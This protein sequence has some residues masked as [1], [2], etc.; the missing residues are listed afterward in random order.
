M[1]GP[2]SDRRGLAV[3]PTGRSS[4]AAKQAALERLSSADSAD[5]ERREAYA[6]PQGLGDATGEWPK[7]TLDQY[8]RST[9]ASSKR[10]SRLRRGK[11]RIGVSGD[12]RPRQRAPPGPGLERPGTGGRRLRRLTARLDAKPGGFG[13][14][15]ALLRVGRR[16][17]RIVRRKPEA[18]PVLGRRQAVAREVPLEQLVRLAV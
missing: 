16:R 7:A 6:V 14:C 13:D 2:R 9:S 12:P 4:P 8:F 17:H 1:A 3:R 10:C 11:L 15:A 5:L 18:S